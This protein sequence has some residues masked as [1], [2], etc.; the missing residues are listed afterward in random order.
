MKLLPFLLC[1]FLLSSSCNNDN[2]ND[3]DTEFSGSGN[4]ESSASLDNSKSK[5][6]LYL[7]TQM[8]SY[9]NSYLIIQWIFLGEDGT[10]VYDPV[11]GVNPVD[12]NAERADN[13]D[14][15][16]KYELNGDQ[17]VVEME[18][19]KSSSQ[20]YETRN[21]NISYIDGG[22]ASIQ[23]GVPAGFKLNGQYSGGA[24]TKN[25]TSTHSYIFNEDGRFS[26]GRLGSV[27][28]ESTD[29]TASSQDERG[30]KYFIN[31]NT[32]T[33]N[34]DD[35]TEEKAIIGIMDIGS[36]KPFLVINQTSFRME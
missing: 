21:G 6:K 9:P 29:G 12:Y 15:V 1:F 17:L 14:N 16:G 10:I 2:G 8:V 18:N 35:G 23:T 30:G 24:I 22:T 34:F 31:G 26:L 3:D 28:T 7:R 36:G 11:H 20:R 5:G 19:G 32:L 27:N 13:A 25:L 4:E 33:L